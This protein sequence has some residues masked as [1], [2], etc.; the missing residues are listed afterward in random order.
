[1]KKKTGKSFIFLFFVLSLLSTPNF[2]NWADDYYDYTLN[3]KS[4][5]SLK[6][7][8]N[9]GLPF[10]TNKNLIV[11]LA[12][13]TSYQTN[14]LI[15]EKLKYILSLEKFNYLKEEP[16]E[17]LLLGKIRGDLN[18][19]YL[20][21]LEELLKMNKLGFRDGKRKF[22]LAHIALGL[23]KGVLGYDSKKV[24]DLYYS[25][26]KLLTLLERQ[27]YPIDRPSPHF[28]LT[29]LMIAAFNGDFASV[30]FLISRKVDKKVTTSLPKREG[31][32]AKD[33]AIEGFSKM[34]EAQEALE[35]D[36]R[37]TINSLILI[38]HREYKKVISLLAAH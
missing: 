20:F 36:P 18:Y 12:A 24:T 34:P 6:L 29:P 38:K 9:L 27:G 37:Y 5:N 21:V 11:Q 7:L 17:E 31:F 10:H 33:F 13:S 2:Q 35:G 25:S 30:K 1:M 14:A 23:E 16:N 26:K 8:T 15:L 19:K 3:S 22:S 4:L 32:T 28:K